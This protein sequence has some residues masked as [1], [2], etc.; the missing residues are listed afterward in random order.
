MTAAR[1]VRRVRARHLDHPGT[2]SATLFTTGSGWRLTGLVRVQYPEGS[3]SVRYRIDADRAW[4]TRTARIDL[5]LEGTRRSVR[6]AAD[7]S[8]RW[9]VAGM[10][11]RDLRGCIDIDLTATAMTNTLPI[12][13]LALPVGSRARIP[14]AWMTFP[15]LEIHP[16]RQIYTRLAR[17]RYR[18][19]AP[20]NG[21]VAEITV[22]DDGIVVDYP[23]YWTR[24]PP[25]A[26]AGRRRAG[27][28]GP[29]GLSNLK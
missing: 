13:R 21:F 25:T 20:H 10:E 18:F 8:G 22:D 17:D 12:R 24:M 1:A 2:E 5:E 28:G 15:D 6:V 3:G 16:V 4:R 23:E 29:G 19:E 26:D 9:D 11:Q 27:S 7:P 14:A